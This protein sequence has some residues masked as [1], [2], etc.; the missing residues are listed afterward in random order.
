MKLTQAGAV[1]ARIRKFLRAGEIRREAVDVPRLIDELLQ[2]LQT[3]LSEAGVRVTVDL[4]AALPP[5][6]ADPVQLQQVIL[7]LVVNAVDALRDLPAAR[8]EVNIAVALTYLAVR[9]L[10]LPIAAIR[11]GARRIGHGDFGHRHLYDFCF[12][13]NVC[14]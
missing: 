4:P 7:N 14:M 1:I 2:M 10:F 12:L 13:T 5:L 3:M 6:T 9:W 11:E 8:R